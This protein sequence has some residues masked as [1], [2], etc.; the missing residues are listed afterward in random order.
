MLS[1]DTVRYRYAGA[2][3][4]SLH[5]V[6]MDLKGGELT[7]LVGASDA[8]KS[9]LCL[10]LGGLAP[11]SIRGDLRGV[12]RIEGAD[13]TAWPQ[14]RFVEHVVVGLQD[15]AG[16]LS[17]VAETV[18]EEV[19][20]GPTNLGLSREEV[21]ERTEDALE[22]LSLDAVAVRDP[23]RLSAGQQQLVVMAGLLAMRPSFLVLDEPL[24]HLDARS[25]DRVMEA[26]SAA[27]EAGTGVLIAEQRTDMLAAH[28]ESLWVIAAGNLVRHGDP[29]AV[30]AEPSV[31]A[32]GIEEPAE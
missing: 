30:L 12:V 26:L 8:G 25:A 4:D 23:R 27:A 7:G 2:A 15:P 6:S 28:C 24:A 20:F 5:G 18:Y 32:M 22:R 3:R 10:V 17:M 9:T 11:R 1:L 21:M 14:H 19:A 31:T 13:V 16:Q 29:S